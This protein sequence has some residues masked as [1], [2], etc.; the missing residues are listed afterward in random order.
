MSRPPREAN[1]EL[2]ETEPAFM[3]PCRKRPC[4]C[5]QLIDENL[6]GGPYDGEPD[7]DAYPAAEAALQATCTMIREKAENV[8]TKQPDSTA[9]HLDDTVEIMMD[10]IE[11]TEKYEYMSDVPE[12]EANNDDS[13]DEENASTAPRHIEVQVQVETER[14]R[15]KENTR[16]YLETSVDNFLEELEKNGGTEDET[17]ETEPPKWKGEVLKK[18]Q[19]G[20]RPIRVIR[21][22]LKQ[23]RLK[24]PN[25]DLKD[26]D[27]HARALFGYWRQYEVIEECLYRIKDR[28]ALAVIP[29]ETRRKMFK[30]LHNS[31]YGGGHMGRTKTIAK[32]NE[33][34]GW[35]GMKQDVCQWIRECEACQL[36]KTGPGQGKLPLI[37]TK[38]GDFNERIAIDL[39]G[40]LPDSQGYKYI[41]TVQDCFTKWCEAYPLES[42]KTA[43]VVDA[44]NK[45]WISRFG[46]P[47]T[48]LSDNGMEFAGK[49]YTDMMRQLGVK[50]LHSS[51]YYPRANGMVERLNATIQDM[52][53]TAIIEMG[54]GLSE[55][56][57]Y[58]TAMYRT[59][60]HETTG[61]TPNMLVLG[62]EV[63][64]PIDAIMMNE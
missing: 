64:L 18:A 51:P 58:I 57:P 26:Y 55:L 25:E 56:L 20:Y 47:Q 24:L 52:L 38:V 42:K 54:N 50:I 30:Q 27:T 36:T 13:S 39:I 44:L 8:R 33:R 41:L 6:V 3:Y 19:D 4:I 17:N 35:P 34:A 29:P 9:N 11:E 5:K 46:A 37:S 49:I 45:E 62:R 14:D 1:K 32:F 15:Q 21:D 61:Y 53:K 60:K 7:I 22:R 63:P 10:E 2:N 16:E 23:T 40:P 28:T 48:I 12:N 43:L 31:P 59:T